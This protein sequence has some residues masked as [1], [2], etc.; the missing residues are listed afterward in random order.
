MIQEGDGAGIHIELEPTRPHATE[1]FQAVPAR[2]NTRAEYDGRSIAPEDLRQLERAAAQDGV[3][4][5]LLT[6]RRAM[7][8]VL[9]LIIQATVAHLND[10]P[11]VDEL[12]AWT[13]FGC[14]PEMPRSLR[15]PLERV[16]A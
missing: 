2:Q 16:I 12:K 4:V 10:P 7:N 9:D 5:L 14:G 3:E 15:R 6:D 8:E 11:W 1:L 13:R